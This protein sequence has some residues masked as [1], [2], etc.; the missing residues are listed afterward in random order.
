M[1]LIDKDTAFRWS[2][3]PCTEERGGY[4][5]SIEGGPAAATPRQGRGYKRHCPRGHRKPLQPRHCP[6]RCRYR[7]HLIAPGAPGA[8][9]RRRRPLQ[10]PAASPQKTASRPLRP[11][12]AR[13]RRRR[14]RRIA[15]TRLSPAPLPRDM[16]GVRSVLRRIRAGVTPAPSERRAT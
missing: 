7:R 9:A 16:S 11:S 10:P 6:C 14:R 1:L 15:S 4:K 8:P 13:I 5:L 2:R 12:R 3:L